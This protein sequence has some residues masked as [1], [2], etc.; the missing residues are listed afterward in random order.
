MP[1]RPR[2]GPRRRAGR[3]RQGAGQVHAQ[4]LAPVA[5]RPNHQ[6]NAPVIPQALGGFVAGAPRLPVQQYPQLESSSVL[7][8]TVYTGASAE[9]VRGFKMLLDG[10]LDHIG[11]TD[12]YMKGGIDEVLA[13]AAKS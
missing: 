4:D 7:I 6:G 9:T 12:F 8:T 13:A 11:E 10:E 5:L 1:P 3:R 2:P